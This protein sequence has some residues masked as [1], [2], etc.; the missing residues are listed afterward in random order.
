MPVSPRDE[1]LLYFLRGD[2]GA[3][4]T[5]PREGLSHSDWEVLIEESGR[6]GL[7]PLFYQRL[8]AFPGDSPVPVWVSRR[9]RLLYLQNAGRNMNL[10]QGLVKVL[11]VMEKNHIP[12]IALKGAHLAELVYGNIA[13][14]PMSD[15]DLLVKKKDLIRVEEKLLELGYRPI[16]G[17]IQGPIEGPIED[18]RKVTGRNYHFVYWMAEK[19]LSLEIHW[20]LIRP[21][22][23]FD[24]DL[25]G[26][27]A[28]SRTAVIGNSA[29]RVQS[30]EDLI[31]HLCLH[32]GKDLF[33]KGLKL[34]C[35]LSETIR[36]YGQEMDWDQVL[37]GS[38]QWGIEK[39]VYLAL[40]LA[41]ELLNASVPED[42][43]KTLRP[44]DF[45]EPYLVSARALIFE[46]IRDSEALFFTTNLARLWGP[47]RFSEKA[48]IFLKRVFPPPELMAR[49]Y[50]VT[51][52]SLKV[53]FYYPKR[54]KDI[55]QG[56]SRQV[57]RLL[58]RDERMTALAERKNKLAPLMDWLNWPD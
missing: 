52:D 39:F 32:T 49:I 57:W 13:L 9:L 28:R 25:E 36:H 27:W 31:L 5:L 37:F 43:L 17:P 47:G 26:Q 7:A 55:L 38:R 19:E 1:W 34:T 53:Y 29:V 33:D 21:D 18:A 44:D 14:R 3:P 20:T 10:Y 2:G 54:I 30:P 22:Y 16:Q 56:H 24:I 51:A 11:E 46:K 35:D 8:K 50:P 40:R 4:K 42:L 6:H 58:V 48:A 41:K 23:P 45:A 15:L 12:V